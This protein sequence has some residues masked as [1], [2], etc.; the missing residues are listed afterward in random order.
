MVLQANLR[1]CLVSIL[2][3]CSALFKGLFGMFLDS[4]MAIFSGPFVAGFVG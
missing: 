1:G 2:N 3:D 4:F